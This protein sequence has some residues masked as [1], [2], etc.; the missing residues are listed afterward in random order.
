MNSS[1]NS[2]GNSVTVQHETMSKKKIWNVFWILTII[3]AVEFIIALVLVPKGIFSVGIANPLYIILTLMKAFYIVAF[4]MHLKF[5]KLTLIY[6]IAIP[7]LFIV[8]LI[9][10]MLYEGNY[11]FDIR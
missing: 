2:T 11:W 1:E 5:E 7:I 3:T 8:A 4:F 9:V 10:A 6:S